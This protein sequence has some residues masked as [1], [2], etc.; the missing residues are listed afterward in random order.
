MLCR[1]GCLHN[2]CTVLTCVDQVAYHS[3][4]IT[5]YT[6]TAF[7][8]TY[9]RVSCDTSCDCV[10]VY[11]LFCT[12]WLI[13]LRLLVPGPSAASGWPCKA[14][15]RRCWTATT[16]AACSS[17]RGC[18][19]QISGWLW[20]CQQASRCVRVYVVSG[21]GREGW[22]S[23]SLRHGGRCRMSACCH[24]HPFV[25]LVFALLVTTTDQESKL[26]VVCL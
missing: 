6:P 14:S 19:R 4:N 12:R 15:A 20:T 1:H 7:L 9:P 23:A 22:T 11:T 10:S 8:N 18:W 24:S 3:T 2:T 16:A 25:G 21:T 17:C 13:M 26:P 5:R